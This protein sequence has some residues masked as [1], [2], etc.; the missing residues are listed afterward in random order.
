MKYSWKILVV[1]AT[2]IF[3][4][5]DA[6][7]ASSRVPPG[8]FTQSRVLSVKQ[9]VNH[10]NNKPNIKQR[11]ASHFSMSPQKIVDYFNKNIKLVSLRKPLRTT[12][13]Y[14]GLDGKIHTKTK[15][16]PRGTPVFAD[17]S[18]RPLIAWSCGNP[19]TKSLTKPKAQKQVARVLPEKEV[20]LAPAEQ[21][22]KSPPSTEELVKASPVETVEAPPVVLPPPVITPPPAASIV[23]AM[24]SNDVYIPPFSQGFTVLDSL[25]G[26]SLLLAGT[27]LKSGGGGGSDSPVPEIPSNIVVMVGVGVIGITQ[28]LRLD[29]RKH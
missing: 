11:F 25:P 23:D 2:I 22:L 13:W 16:L 1:L 26:V 10:L 4:S 18:G 7:A 5:A 9:L 15:L 27:A 21:P 12:V 3:A 29:R 20:A 17:L 6:H 8:S 19:L 28:K 14:V 24:L